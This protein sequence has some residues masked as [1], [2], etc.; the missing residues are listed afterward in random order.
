LA[1]GELWHWDAPVNDDALRFDNECENFAL[2][3]DAEQQYDDNRGSSSPVPT[4]VY[5]DTPTHSQDEYCVGEWQT[6]K[7]DYPGA[8]IEDTE[9]LVMGKSA[10]TMFG[11]EICFGM[12]S[13]KRHT[14]LPSLSA[15]GKT[16]AGGNNH[17]T[18]VTNTIYAFEAIW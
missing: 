17:S 12:V 18:A 9:D 11:A 6:Q 14:F 13:I 8:K 7:L 5:D 10:C 16:V 1:D 2:A 4:A 3:Y 15:N